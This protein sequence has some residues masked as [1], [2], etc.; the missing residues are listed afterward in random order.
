[1]LTQH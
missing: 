1:V